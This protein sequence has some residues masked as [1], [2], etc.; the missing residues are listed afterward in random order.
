MLLA[1]HA[2]M[3]AVHLDVRTIAQEEGGF[4]AGSHFGATSAPV[5]VVT[6]W[7]LNDLCRIGTG[8]GGRCSGVPLAQSTLGDWVG[9]TGFHLT[10]LWE[11]LKALLLARSVLHADEL[12]VQQLAPG[13]G[14]THKAY[15]W[16]YCANTLDHGSSPASL[17]LPEQS[18]RTARSSVSRRMA[19][20]SVR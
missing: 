2:I 11:R 19:R 3:V 7:L 5:T 15:L 9:R 17:R 10:P 13:T 6:G 1:G 12:P 16:A 14:K 8:E 18:S 20:H 4:R